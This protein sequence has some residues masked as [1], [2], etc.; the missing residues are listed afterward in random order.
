MRVE[1][2]PK[3]TA[4]T[5]G[6]EGHAPLHNGHQG[7]ARKLSRNPRSGTKMP[8]WIVEDPSVL[9]WICAVSAVAFF[10]IFLVRRTIRPLV[11]AGASLAI[12][13]A[14]LFADYLVVTDREAIA[15]A[16]ETLERAFESED[17]PAIVQQLAPEFRAN[18]L[19][20]TGAE[21]M[22]RELFRLADIRRLRI[23]IRQLDVS[24]DRSTA[25]VRIEAIADGRYAEGEFSLYRTSWML[26][27][28]RRGDHNWL[29][30]R[31]APIG[32]TRMPQTRAV[33][34][35]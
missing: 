6:P 13:G 24:A 19:D 18:G 30:L 28:V 2:E 3:L 34:R 12:G 21:Q 5:M 35:R 7:G 1:D 29:I 32:D 10:A 11:G 8:D 20:R 23:L 17:V 9:L 27:F 26:T 25:T 22:L 33:R 14:L 15:Y 31:V 16:L 4:F